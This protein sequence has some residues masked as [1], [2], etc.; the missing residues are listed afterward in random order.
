VERKHHRLLF[1]SHQFAICHRRGR[2]HAKRLSGQTT[3]SEELSLAQY[4]QGCFLA[5]LRDNGESDLTFLDVEDG[6]SRV[7][8]REDC[9]FPGKGNALP[10][11]TDSGKEFP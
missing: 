8:L 11:L 1:D 5:N 9:M 3:F 2:P 10:A 4:A 6:V 7:P